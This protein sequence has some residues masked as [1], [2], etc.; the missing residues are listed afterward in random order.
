MMEGFPD[1]ETGLQMHSSG[2]GDG[3]VHC[4]LRVKKGLNHKGTAPRSVL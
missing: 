2:E 4:R 1:E 3:R